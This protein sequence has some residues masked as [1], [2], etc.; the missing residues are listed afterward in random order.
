MQSQLSILIPLSYQKQ[1][2]VL[3]NS[4]ECVDAI[5][6]TSGQKNLATTTRKNPEAI[7]IAVTLDLLSGGGGG[8]ARNT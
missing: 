3:R 4:N 6:T 5:S 8:R 1:E 7:L 2:N